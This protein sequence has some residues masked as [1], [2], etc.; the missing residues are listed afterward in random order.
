MPEAKKKPPG[1]FK[2]IINWFKHQAEWIQENLGDPLLAKEILGDLGLNPDATLPQSE[3]DKLPAFARDLDPEK[4][5]FAETAV[6]IQDAVT[7]LLAIADAA[8][9]EQL[10]GWDTMFYLGTISATESIRLRSPLFFA[11]GEAALILRD[12]PEELKRLD[13]AILVSL[14]RGEGPPPGGAELFHQRLF[15][16]IG[17]LT[18]ILPHVLGKLG[19]DRNSTGI[20]VEPYYGWDPAPDSP[21]PESDL[22]S[23]RALTM[24]FALE[25]A[26]AA[27]LAITVVS[28]PRTQGG[29]G[30]FLSVGGSLNADTVIDGTRYIITMGGSGAFDLF[31]P[32][33][34]GARSLVGGGDPEAF[35][36]WDVSRS[37][38]E[39]PALRIGEADHTR[40]DVGTV[41]LGLELSA[42][43]GG[44][45]FTLEDAALILKMSEGDG[46][47]QTLSKKELAIRFGFGIVFD[48]DA[49]LR[50][51][52]GTN[53][54]VTIPVANSVLGV[55]TIHHLDLRLGA[56]RQP[57]D[58]ALEVSAALG[59]S[60]GPFRASIDRIGMRFEGGFRQG[61]LG[62]MDVGLGFRAPDGIGLIL[63]SDPVK[64]GGYL[65][66]DRERGEYA[67]ILDVKLGP[68]NI[69]AIGILQTGS[70]DRADW[71]LLIFL[72]GQFPPIHLGPISWTGAGGM[73]GVRRAPDVDK[74]QAGVRAGALDDIL[75]PKDPV[76]DAPR[77]INELRAI[78]P[79]A[80]GALT[81][82]PFIELGFGTPPVVIA[83]LGVIF[84]FDRVTPGEDSRDLTR[85]F[86]LGQIIAQAPP[87][88]KKPVVK[89]IFDIF[90]LI[91]LQAK[92][93]LFSGR[94]RDSK[95]LELT[96]TGMIVVRKDYGD[97]PVFILSA[98]GFHPDFKDLPPG[99]PAPIDRLG[100]APIKIAGF[101]LEVTCYFAITPNTKQAGF[102]GKAKATLGSLSLEASLS[103]DALIHDEP[104]THFV[105]KTKLTAHIKYKGHS[106]AGVKI[107][108][109]I[110]GPGY[111]RISGKVVF[112]ILWWDIEIPFDKET[113]E[114]P[115]IELPAVN[116]GG[117]VQAALANE[118]AWQAQLP[119]GGEA[120][121][122]I[123]KS[124]GA[125]GTF[126]HPLASL[127][128]LQGV[129]PLGVAI[130][131][132]GSARVAG[133]NRFDI[134]AVRIG[135]D[136]IATP[137]TVTQPFGRGQ[138][139]D[140]TD[141][142]RLTLPS[143]EAFPA[144][145]TVGS[146]D[147]TFGPAVA[148]DLTYE[149]AYLEMEPEQ[150]RG[151][152]I[153]T[154][155][156]AAALPLSALDWQPKSGAAAR[157]A[158]RATAASPVVRTSNVTV[159][160]PPLVAVEGDTLEP[161]VS[162]VLEGAA[163]VSPTVAAQRIAAAGPSLAILEAFEL[164]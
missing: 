28:V 112:E 29:P 111:W 153:R 136:T 79:F 32:L 120:F 110:E 162:V 19:V 90:G 5:S 45:S 157:S 1:I 126:A 87:K 12:D 81:F 93:V 109:T 50:L 51:A 24:T 88:V 85:I 59:L 70:A 154:Q 73:L 40:L 18:G 34:S 48:T 65:F 152:I 89:L 141:E 31:I 42:K 163:A 44:L 10:S 156:V 36:R 67:G 129:A 149:T 15:A 144:G 106:L 30:L 17:L 108:A 159:D 139:F 155:L 123:A 74:L 122:T 46:F 137:D 119:A 133:A 95:I 94:L 49:G 8:K 99:L 131:R 54:S 82:G 62:I 9:N 64:G 13:P 39:A 14:L 43:S 16:A 69:K 4:E 26:P 2:R 130:E 83:R 97:K 72:F 151:R 71:S 33:G 53:A 160:A 148:A 11:L 103:F 66:L 25:A 7:A 37:D 145:I 75:F 38:P 117:L 77:L 134:T 57:D 113:G 101:K 116:V 60:I 124:A 114:K 118:A 115:Q 56:G 55:F 47:L 84:Q 142:Q 164:E 128:V 41:K 127:T 96:L 121:V 92:T 102:A 80:N 100:V 135:P 27:R 147:F 35:L 20:I 132:F 86:V 161:A 63:D 125:Q 6:E 91:D 107:D 158:M 98:G 68:V 21:T 58:F 52:G 78:F 23:M 104:Y 22:V 105:V 146:A 76:A 61:N 140:L 143:F 138:F 150:P 3:M